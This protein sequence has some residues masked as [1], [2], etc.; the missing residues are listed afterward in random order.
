M[1]LEVNVV[2]SDSTRMQGPRKEVNENV[3]KISG[4]GLYQVTYNTIRAVEN[5]E[6]LSGHG[7]F[8]TTYNTVRAVK[9]DEPLPGH[10]LFQVLYNFFNK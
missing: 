5:D 4:H 6:P 2:P 9:K 7:L 10:G 3:Q 1:G 8:Q